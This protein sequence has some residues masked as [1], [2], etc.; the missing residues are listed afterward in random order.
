MESFR[1]VPDAIEIDVDFI[2]TISTHFLNKT[3]NSNKILCCVV[4]DSLNECFL[5]HLD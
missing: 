1:R 3:I 5:N 2:N 4:M